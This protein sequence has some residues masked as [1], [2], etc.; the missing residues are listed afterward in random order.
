MK[1]VQEEL[2]LIDLYLWFD[3]SQLAGHIWEGENLE[4]QQLLAVMLGLFD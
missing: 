4:H 3:S 2:A 1:S